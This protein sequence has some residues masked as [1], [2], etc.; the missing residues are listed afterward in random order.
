MNNNKSA[1]LLSL[2]TGARPPRVVERNLA[3]SPPRQTDAAAKE[4]ESERRDRSHGNPSVGPCL[5]GCGE[6]II[7]IIIIIGM[8]VVDP[9]RSRQNATRCASE[10]Q[11]LATGS[12]ANESSFFLGPWTPQSPNAAHP[13]LWHP[14]F[15][16]R[17][18]RRRG[19]SARRSGIHPKEIVILRASFIPPMRRGEADPRA[20]RKT[21]SRKH[22]RYYYS[23]LVS[24]SRSVSTEFSG[25][26]RGGI[27]L[28]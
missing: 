4:K 20:L 5:N 18:T 13:L 22:S 21:S 1:V 15:D 8:I 26:F 16:R 25:S 17:C 2:S 3:A 12:V 11:A 19:S 6:N 14:R 28:F 10:W 23:F 7:I 24:L 27:S 9:R